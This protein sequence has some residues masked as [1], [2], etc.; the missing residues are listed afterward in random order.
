LL[1]NERFFDAKKL[2]KP[3]SNPTMVTYRAGAA[4]S[5]IL[6]VFFKNLAQYDCK[7]LVLPN[8]ID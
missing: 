8:P 7:K 6:Q 2:K 3:G 4:V 1:Q 5:L